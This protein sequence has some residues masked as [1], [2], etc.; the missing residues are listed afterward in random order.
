M[1]P[2]K[3]IL[4]TANKL[5]KELESLGKNKVKGKLYEDAKKTL[6]IRLSGIAD[7]LVS[8]SGGK[9]KEISKKKVAA[10]IDLTE[11]TIKELRKR[12]KT[13]VP[14][15]EQEIEIRKPNPYVVFANLL[16]HGLARKL[17]EKNKDISL[18]VKKANLN[19]LP[20]SFIAIVLL[21]TLLALILGL[22]IAVLFS[23]LS[24]KFTPLPTIHFASPSL[25]KIVF[26]IFLFPLFFVLITFVFSYYYPRLEALSRVNKIDDELPFVAMH[27]SAI[28]S[29]GVEPTRVFKLISETK[30]YKNFNVETKRIVNKINFYGY[31]LLTAIKETAKT[32]PSDKSRDLF[33]GI[34]S[35]IATGGDLKDYLEKKASSLMLDYKLKRKKF[36][37]VAGV[38]ADIY[39]GLLI[40]API[41]FGVILSMIAPLGGNIFGMNAESI[42]I[43]GLI[44]II[45]FNIGFIIFLNTVQ[46]AE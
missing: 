7:T 31:D 12:I 32:T 6:L 35:V 27:M 2:I 42:A 9:T 4:N 38:Y 24:F 10:G 23:F 15:P 28:V 25:L 22:F 11:R 43:I 45:M 1:M 18:D 36:V 37:S 5:V 16:F 21:N 41:I 39:T 17:A 20:S 29:S 8:I 13:K 44:I 19:I 33:N 26:N 3:Q 14:K 34:A 30:E 46:P 40:T